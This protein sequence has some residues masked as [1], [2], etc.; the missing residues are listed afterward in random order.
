MNRIERQAADKKN[1]GRMWKVAKLAG[2]RRKQSLHVLLLVTS[3]FHIQGVVICS[4]SGALIASRRRCLS[5]IL[6]GPYLD[7]DDDDDD[8]AA[9]AALGKVLSILNKR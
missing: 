5:V 9:A 1:K 7:G 6:E 4:L 8:A 3:A 2:T